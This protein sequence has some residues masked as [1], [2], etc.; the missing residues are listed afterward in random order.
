[1]TRE[2]AGG[3]CV[4]KACACVVRGAGDLAELLVFDHPTAG[5]QLPKGT[6]ELC[7]QPAQAVLRELAE[8]TRLLDPGGPRLL[9]VWT[10]T[11]GAGPEEAGTL[12]END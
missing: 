9:G 11:A 6:V 10:R 2:D 5:T 8:E 3:R 12:E 4:Q 1:M 7:E